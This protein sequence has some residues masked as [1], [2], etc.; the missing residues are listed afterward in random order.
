MLNFRKNRRD[1]NEARLREVAAR[2]GAHWIEAPPL[3]GW[4]WVN[5]WGTWMP[6]ECKRP[7][8]EGLKHEYT[9]AQQRFI[10][11]CKDRG[12][13]WLVWRTDRDVIESLGGR[14]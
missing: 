10:E 14:G 6:V 11:W 2:L 7:E 4:I 12:A 13:K 5:R 9:P 1:A 8:R 3:D